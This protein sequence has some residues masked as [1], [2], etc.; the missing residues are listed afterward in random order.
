VISLNEAT[1]P[2]D[3]LGVSPRHPP[4]TEPIEARMAN[5]IRE[6]SLDFVGQ[7]DDF[8]KRPAYSRMPTR[9]RAFLD[10]PTFRRAICYAFGDQWTRLAM[11]SNEFKQ[12]CIKNLR[13]DAAAAS[14]SSQ[15]I[16]QPEPLVLWQPFAYS[17]MQMADGDKYKI[18]LRGELDAEKKALFEQQKLDAKAAE[19]EYAV[20]VGADVGGAKSGTMSL[21][22][23]QAME[24]LREQEAKKK[25]EDMKPVG[26]RGARV[27][28]VNAAK[29][30][31]RDR[32]M[33][34]NAT[35][36]KAL[37]DLDEDGSG[38]LARDEIKKFLK[39]QNLMKYF[40]FY[41]GMTRGELDPKVVD[42]LLDMVDADG[43]GEINYDEFSD[44]VMA[45][46]N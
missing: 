38:V 23:Y 10:V 43:N 15:S 6:R 2:G 18:K 42:T 40:D 3:V 24:G 1:M 27:G 25:K 34:K 19:A 14:T 17:L 26:V 45:G 28:E 30:V 32:L 46:V 12:I 22:R 9:N 7:V 31:I 16:G 4:V 37:K 11:T 20:G 35:V 33:M 5:I 44:V 21:A 36:R 13:N 39:E 29:V 41:T 8:L